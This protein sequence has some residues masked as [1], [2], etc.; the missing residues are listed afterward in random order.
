MMEKGLGLI[1]CFFSLFLESILLIF[2]LPSLNCASLDNSDLCFAAYHTWRALNPCVSPLG[3]PHPTPSIASFWE[4][5][6]LQMFGLLHG[7]RYELSVPL[8]PMRD[9]QLPAAYQHL[10]HRWKQEPCSYHVGR[11]PVKDAWPDL[12]TQRG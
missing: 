3:T 7:G 9:K 4:L 12:Q 5:Q 1:T 10:W 11:S 2:N 6:W 8:R